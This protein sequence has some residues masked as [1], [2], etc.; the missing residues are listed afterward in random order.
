MTRTRDTPYLGNGYRVS[1]V[2]VRV[3]LGYPRVTRAIP[4]CRLRPDRG[5]E[6]LSDE[7]SA[8]LKSTRTVWKLT[9]HDMPEHNSVSEW[10][11]CMIMEKVWVMLLDSS[12]PKFLWKEAVTHTVYLKN[13]TWTR[14]I[15]NTTP[16]EILYGWKPNI[17]NLHT[18]GCKVCHCLCSLWSQLETRKL[19]LWWLLDGFWW[20]HQDGHRVYWPKKRKV[21]VERNIK[22]NFDAEEVVVGLPLEGEILENERLTAIEPDEP[23]HNFHKDPLVTA[24]PK[25]HRMQVN[26]VPF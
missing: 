23:H 24:E 4:Y 26:T 17:G 1:Q 10:L 14:T 3:G 13:H 25:N 7:F 22:I 5:G 15:G 2:R 16:Y 11:N 8:H 9:I 20:R 6:Y 19:F 21:T 18:W 12:M